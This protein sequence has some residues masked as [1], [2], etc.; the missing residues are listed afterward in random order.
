M[1]FSF[2]YFKYIF[3]KLFKYFNSVFVKDLRASLFYIT[4]NP[5]LYSL[6]LIYHFTLY[7]INHLSLFSSIFLLMNSYKIYLY[8][9]VYLVQILNS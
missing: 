2:N 6:F 3:R 4:I 7:Y 8:L 1:I 9:H 5:F